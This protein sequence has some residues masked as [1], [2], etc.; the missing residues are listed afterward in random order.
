MAEGAGLKGSGPWTAQRE[1]IRSGL[2]DAAGPVYAQL[3]E[4]LVPAVF[5]YSP[6]SGSAVVDLM[7]ACHL[8]RELMNGLPRVL[9]EAGSNGSGA[10]RKAVEHLR[11]ALLAIRDPLPDAPDGAAMAMVLASL[12]TPLSK[13]RQAVLEG[14]KTKTENA[15]IVVL[16]HP[17]DGNPAI[18]SWAKT[19]SFFQKFVHVN[20]D[21]SRLPQRDEL[22]EAL[23]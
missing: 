3:Y 1:G 17:D 13:F 2:A 22:L 15:A 16:G 14:S 18:I 9:G 11:E 10:E 12:V 23:T 4:R 19:E 20:P 8:A 21:V 7:V 6:S 5:V